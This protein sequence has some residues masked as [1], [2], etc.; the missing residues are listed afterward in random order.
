M[1]KRVLSAAVAA[2]CLAVL[3]AGSA[4]AQAVRG[5]LL[6]NITDQA[7]LALP[8]VSVTVTETNTNISST[9]TTNESGYYT[10]PS[11]KDGTY[12]VTAELAG[13]K[14]TVRE[15]VIVD[16]NT[17]IRVDLKLEVGAI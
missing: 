14:K 15:G 6:G 16:V 5:G 3:S 13:F 2:A 11:L 4:S 1:M 8:G 12:K 10:F 7:G 17:T 9:S